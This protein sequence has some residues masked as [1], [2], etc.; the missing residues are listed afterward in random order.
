VADREPTGEVPVRPAVVVPPRRRRLRRVLRVLAVLLVA[1]A[2]YFAVVFVEVWRF[3]RRDQARAVDAIVVMGAAQYDGRPSP[4]LR[5][6]LDHALGLYQR[7]LAPLVVVTG[8]KQPGDRF[9]E[10]AV[11]AR[12]LA[13]RGV[14]ESSIVQEPEGRTSW[15][16]LRAVAAVLRQRGA[17]RVLLV[18]DPYH[19]RR[20]VGMVDDLGLRAWSSPTRTSPEGPTHLVPH[21]AT[22]T[23]GV[24]LA[25]VIGFRHLVWV[26]PG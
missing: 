2:L 18:S 13:D 4:V 23:L 17:S 5:A 12:F 19:E 21:Y 11:G 10:A 20:I 26:D 9:T 22:E 14:P 7:G 25:H 16:S 6:R 1:V 15:Q 3:G 8:G 24:G